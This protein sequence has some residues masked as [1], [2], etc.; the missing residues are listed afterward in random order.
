M[1]NRS[2]LD[3]YTGR[4]I[5]V[6]EWADV[7]ESGRFALKYRDIESY[8]VYLIPSGHNIAR[9]VTKFHAVSLVR[10][11]LPIA[12][13]LESDLNDKPMKYEDKRKVKAAWLSVS[14]ECKRFSEECRKEN[15]EQFLA[16]AREYKRQQENRDVSE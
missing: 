3:G 15:I 10:V 4:T 12:D 11:M 6:R 9:R 14:D 8:D 16:N 1:D 7:D 13:L 2:L 5:M